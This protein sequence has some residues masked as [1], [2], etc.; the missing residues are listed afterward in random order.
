MNKKELL[1]PMKG[2]Y[3]KKKNLIANIILKTKNFSPR[4]RNKEKMSGFPTSSQYCTREPRTHN[5]VSR[6]NKKDSD[7]KEGNKTVNL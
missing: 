3:I 7:C 5:K 4:I 6:R 2:I 1:Q